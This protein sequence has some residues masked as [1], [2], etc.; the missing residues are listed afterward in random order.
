[1]PT[2]AIASPRT[3]SLKFA[4]RAAAWGLGL[5]GFL[6]LPWIEA[7][8]VLP[9]TQFQGRLAALGSGTA[10]LP[11]DVSLACSGTDVLSLCVAAILAYPARWRARIAGAGAG[12]LLILALNTVRIATLARAVESPALFN[13]LHVYVWPVALALAVAAYVFWWMR[14]ADGPIDVREDVADVPPS[15]PARAARLFVLLTVLFILIFAA[16]SPWYLN[17]RWVLAV[18]VFVTQMGALVL[19]LGGIAASAAGNV[20]V[21]ARGSF[22]VTEEC[23]VTPLMPAYLAAVLAYGRRWQRIVPA[24][25]AAVPLFVA[26][27]V[28]RLLVVAIPPA[29]IG[30]PLFLIHAFYQILT[31]CV[32][33]GIAAWWRHGSGARTWRRTSAALAAGTACLLL[34]YP[35]SARGVASTMIADEQSAMAMLPAF[36]VA[37]FMALWI[38]AFAPLRRWALAI[39]VAAIGASLAAGFAA[40]EILA[41][42]PHARDV[43]AWALAGPLLLIAGIG[44]HGRTRA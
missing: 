27:G 1:M 19:A 40:L 21:T 12:I 43:R 17:S 14:A 33:I 36:Q 11:V 24:L 37:F 22:L 10:V 35:L 6:R 42:T 38:A 8:A 5:V 20:L 30:S 26:L 44:M 13:A 31:A 9:L 25:V 23:I 18:A 2:A 3:A 16:A 7:G 28:A 32:V 39:G 29:L 41:F 15:P 4:A 34:L